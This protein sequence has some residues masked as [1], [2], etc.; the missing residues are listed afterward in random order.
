MEKINNLLIKTYVAVTNKKGQG[1]VEYGLIV[2]GIAVAVM[3]AVFLLG[4]KIAG[5][6]DQVNTQ[7]VS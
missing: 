2:A 1:M 6:F 3:A 4:D 5:F 7:I